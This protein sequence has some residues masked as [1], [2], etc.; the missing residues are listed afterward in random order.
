MYKKES[1]ITAVVKNFCEYPREESSALLS[2][3]KRSKTAHRAKD[4]PPP[5]DGPV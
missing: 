3:D 2:G 5:V 4:G 1:K